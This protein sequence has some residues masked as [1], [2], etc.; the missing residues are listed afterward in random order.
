MRAA[1]QVLNI[2]RDSELFYLF[3]LCIIIS[4]KALLDMP[5]DSGIVRVYSMYVFVLG[6]IARSLNLDSSRIFHNE[7]QIMLA[8]D[9]TLFFTKDDVMCL[10]S[11]FSVDKLMELSYASVYVG[12]AFIPSCATLAAKS[13]SNISSNHFEEKSSYLCVNSNELSPSQFSRPQ[14]TTPDTT[15]SCSN[16]SLFR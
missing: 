5:I 1:S 9:F 7:M 10:D 2:T 4:F 3:I 16:Y 14:I 6:A 13:Y 15:A 8:I 12:S 11:V